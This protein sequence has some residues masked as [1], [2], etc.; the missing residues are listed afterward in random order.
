M[1]PASIF[2]LEV[3]FTSKKRESDY[4]FITQFSLD[5]SSK[6]LKLTTSSPNHSLT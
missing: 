1:L 4:F 5:M 2:D 3:H 6:G